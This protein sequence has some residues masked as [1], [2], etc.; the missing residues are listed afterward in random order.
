LANHAATI[1]IVL[2][3]ILIGL[4]IIR[5]SLTTVPGGK[6]LAFI[7]LFIL[8][9]TALALGAAIHLED[10]KSTDFCLSCHPMAPYGKSLR[11]DDATYIPGFHFQNNLIPTSAA[12]YTCHTTYTMFGGVK[13]KLGGLRHLYI[14]YFGTVPAKLALYEPF[15]NRECLHCHAGM[16][17]FEESS[18]HKEMRE[19]LGANEMSCV[20]CHNKIHDVQHVDQIKLWKGP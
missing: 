8:P 16:R 12:C 18:P 15:N 7:A 9:I 14:Y 2:T 5:P 6:I 11:I 10:A 13:A 4:L 19:Q 17:V 20:T 1:L 3:I